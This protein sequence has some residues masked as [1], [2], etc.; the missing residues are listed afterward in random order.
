MVGDHYLI[1]AILEKCGDEPF[2]IVA[3]QDGNHL[4][5]QCFRKVSGLAYKLQ[6]D[7]LDNTASL[8]CEHIYVLV[9][10]LVDHNL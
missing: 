7:R 4:L 3:G 9:V 6:C 8:F 10:V 1:G 2:H 5:S